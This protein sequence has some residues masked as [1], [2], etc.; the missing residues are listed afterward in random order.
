MSKCDIIIPVWNQLELTKDS[1]VSIEK[2]TVYP[3]RLLIVDNAS[4]AETAEFLEKLNARLGE[5][6]ILVKN[7]KNEGFIKAVN[8]GFR[9]SSAEYVCVLNNDTTVYPSWLTE[10][11]A[12]MDGDE[13][14]AIVNPSSNTLGQRKPESGDAPAEKGSYVETGSAFG[15]CMLIRKKLFDEIGFFD[16]V[17]GMGNFEDTDFSLRAKEKGYITVRSVNSYVYHKESRSFKLLKSFK[18][19]FDKNKKM[20]EKKWGKTKRV[21][22]VFEEAHASSREYLK[23]VL[24]EYAREKSWVYVISPAFDT[25]CFFE[26]HSNLTFYHYKKPVYAQAFFKILFKK[27]KPDVI[28]CG[29]TS[30]SNFLKPFKVFHNAKIEKVKE[31]A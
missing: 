5:K 14:I 17:Y 10:M 2:N 29:S 30:F 19:D 1:I 9:L 31:L 20:F 23:G 16:E 8:E 24:K 12:V 28:F 6:V 13:R 3:Y 26:R 15:F 22:V 7:K 25:K 18:K 4:N 21:M 27:K 11:V